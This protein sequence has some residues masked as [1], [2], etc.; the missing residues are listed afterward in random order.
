MIGIQH[1]K[2]SV[3]APP[4]EKWVGTNNQPALAISTRVVHHPKVLKSPKMEDFI[5]IMATYNEGTNRTSTESVG[6][7]MIVIPLLPVELG[8]LMVAVEVVL[9]LLIQNP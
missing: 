4:I 7:A 9:V 6:L 8:I 5:A 2:I 1:E 3:L